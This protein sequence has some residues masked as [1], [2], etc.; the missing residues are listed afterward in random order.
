VGSL[1]LGSFANQQLHAIAISACGALGSPAAVADQK[2]TTRT[3][4]HEQRR[5]AVRAAAAALPIRAPVQFAE[6]CESNVLTCLYATTA[7]FFFSSA[8][9]QTPQQRNNSMSQSGSRMSCNA[10]QSPWV[11]PPVT[12]MWAKGHAWIERIKPRLG[13]ALAV[14]MP[15]SNGEAQTEPACCWLLCYFE[16]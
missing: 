12:F 8:F 14:L 5:Y 1:G 9:D 15:V 10:T 16:A 13:R 11:R 2:K 3:K 7:M 6:D 4:G